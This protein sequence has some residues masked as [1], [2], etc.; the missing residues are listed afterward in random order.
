M[1]NDIKLLMICTGLALAFAIVDSAA[2]G[3]SKS[4]GAERAY[5]DETKAVTLFSFDDVSI[6]FTQN[7]KMRMRRPERHPS[8]P[9][10]KIG[11]SGTVDSWA[12]QFYGSVI[13]DP[14]GGK[15]RMWYCASS[16]EERK[17]RSIPRSSLWRVAYAESEDGVNWT[18]P[19]LGLVESQGGKDNNL[20]MLDPPMGVL[21][22]KVLHEPDDPN[23]EHCYKM[24]A[25]VWFPKDKLRLGT[26]APYVSADGLTWKLLADIQPVDGEMPHDETLI[27]PLH[28]EPMGG[29]YKW[30]GL[31]HLSGQNAN[32]A[33]RPY[34][35][36]VTRKFI[37]PDFVNWSQSSAIGFVRTSQHKILGNGRSLEGEQTHEGV[38]VWNRGN[39]L[40]GTSGL[41]HGA[42]EWPDIRVDLGFNISN[43]GLHFREPMHNRV[44]I[45]RGADG[46]WDQGGVLQ[47]Q[48]FENVGDHTYIYYGACDYGRAASSPPRG[49]VGIAMLPRDRF[50]DLTVANKMRGDG[51]YQMPEIVSEFMTTSV[52]LE[53]GSHRFYLNADGLGDEASLKV[54]LLDHKTIPIPEYSG[55]KAAIVTSSGFQVPVEWG[56]RHEVDGLPERVRLKVTFEGKNNTDIRFSALYIR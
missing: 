15:F 9:V 2:G 7:L 6:P 20:V 40:I 3:D 24:G 47:G 46:D 43:D 37:S 17:D 25:H 13:R 1:M 56:G 19:H 32:G 51:I 35:G 4:E 10:V 33:P 41:W 38:S 39:V 18:K 44:F 27:P 12:V 55:D 26:I 49:G 42:K 50:A 30:D 11:G 45:K 28:M 31:Y 21:N 23:P 48:G 14:A 34:H 53:G 16:K 22:L 8:N 52:S 29:L 54:E 5:F 36:R